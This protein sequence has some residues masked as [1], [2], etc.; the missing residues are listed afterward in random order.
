MG[1]LWAKMNF[2]LHPGGLSKVQNLTD[3]WCDAPFGGDTGDRGSARCGD[4]L[5]YP[6]SD[7]GVARD[8]FCEAGKMNWAKHPPRPF[9]LAGL[10]QPPRYAK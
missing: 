6:P 5:L 9:R 8:S 10:T 7:P 1:G 3:Q 2:G 4:C